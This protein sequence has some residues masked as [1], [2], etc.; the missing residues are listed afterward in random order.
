MPAKKPSAIKKPTIP[1]V[2]LSIV[3]PTPKRKAK[4]GLRRGEA[5][6]LLKALGGRFAVD[7]ALGLNLGTFTFPTDQRLGF[8][9]RAIDSDTKTLA[10]D[11]LFGGRYRSTWGEQDELFS[12]ASTRFFVQGLLNSLPRDQIADDV[13]QRWT[14]MVDLI[15]ALRI[16][17]NYSGF[18]TATLVMQHPT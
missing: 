11:S 9:D 5:Y 12:T 16:P 15:S 10:K 2:T 4:G 7:T 8:L 6:N 14:T 17:T 3:K 1:G 18:S 13:W